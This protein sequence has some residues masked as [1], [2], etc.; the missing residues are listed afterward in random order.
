[1]THDLEPA[2][3]V[4]PWCHECLAVH[5]LGDPPATCPFGGDDRP[6]DPQQFLPGPR[7]VDPPV[8]VGATVLLALLLLAIAVALGASW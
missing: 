7:L 8:R 4:L 3:P 1:M 5:P 2:D 6:S